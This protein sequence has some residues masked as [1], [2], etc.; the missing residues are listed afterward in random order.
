MAALGYYPCLDS[1][2]LVGIIQQ[3]SNGNPGLERL[4]AR[5][6]LAKGVVWDGREVHL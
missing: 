1:Q 5:Y 4:H 3:D 6:N 2:T